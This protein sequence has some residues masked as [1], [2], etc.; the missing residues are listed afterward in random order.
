M[1]PIFT[2]EQLAEIKAYHFPWYL[3]SALFPLIRLALM[4]LMLGV[5]N[6]PYYRLAESAAGRLEGRFGGLRTAPVIRV[7]FRVFDRLWG[8]SGWGAAL[9]FALS[10]HLTFTLLFLPADIYFF[11]VLEHRYGMSTYT[12]MGF[13]GDMAK[14]IS[15]GTMLVGCMVFGLYGLAR[16]IKRW[17]LVLGVP[18]GVLMLLASALDPYRSRVYFDQK[19]LEAGPL[20]TEITALLKRADIAFADVLV[21]ETS[22]A[23]KRIQAYFAGQGPTRTIVLNDVIIKEFDTG[24]ILAAVAHE[25]G[26]VNESRWPGRIGASVALVVLLFVIDR[27]LR[28]SASRGWFGTHQFA[29]IRTLPALMLLFFLLMNLFGPIAAVFS[30]EKE[31]EADRYALQLTG[32]AATFRRMLVKA[33]RVN[34]MDPEPPRWVVLKGLSH[35]PIGERIEAIPRHLEKAA[36]DGS[37][38]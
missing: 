5:L 27:L 37:I 28:L 25:A 1:D 21:E 13:F 23:S 22:V 26:H 3:R 15:L 30:R 35:P 20:R 7:F 33:A 31:Y 38:P 17:W 14:S 19:P 8:G 11:Y 34:K 6:K 16:R 12:P 36:A 24:E 10:L 4:A 32:D 18:V 9:L 2:P 29:D